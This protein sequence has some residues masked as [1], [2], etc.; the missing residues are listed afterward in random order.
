[1]DSIRP[2]GCAPDKVEL[3]FRRPINCNSIA[4]DGSDF[5]VTGST[6][7]SVIG[8]AGKCVSGV[9]TSI[10]VKLSAPLQ[11]TGNYRVTLK[12][13]TDGNTIIDD[14]GQQTLP[15]AFENFSTGD[16]VNADFT[17]QLFLGCKA[18]SVK[19]AHDGD[20]NINRWK[21]NFDGD[22]KSNDQ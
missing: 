16:T 2:V 9:A 3:V 14:C 1:M 13:G 11:T 22:G 17:Y 10:F 21:W 8:A 18:D 7:V 19:F 5:T 15:G 20:N 4:A 12:T 6:P